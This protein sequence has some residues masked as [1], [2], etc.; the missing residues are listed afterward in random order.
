MAGKAD[1]AYFH[2]VGASSQIP[3]IYLWS[4]RL[5]LFV[6]EDH[7]LAARDMVSAAELAMEPPLLFARANPLR[8]IIEAVLD[9]AGF[10]AAPP[11]CEDDDFETLRGVL[12][13][14]AGMLPLFGEMARRFG[15]QPGVCRLALADALP[16]VDVRR[17]VAP[18]A[19]DDPMA[20]ALLESLS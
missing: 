1:I 6:G 14:G 3:S 5:S 17:A 16:T 10:G 7:P 12:L 9:R 8:P 20:R 15:E 2:A 4:E 18:G 13:A 19:L 11:L